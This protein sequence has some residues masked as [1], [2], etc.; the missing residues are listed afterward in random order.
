L[1]EAGIVIPV[2]INAKIFRDFAFFDSFLRQKRWRPLALFTGILLCSAFLCFI[3]RG[4][5]EQAV[6]LGGVLTAVGLGLPAAYFLSFLSS[7]K[8]QIKKMRLATQRHAY[9]LTLSGTEGIAV[10][11]G[12]EQL[13]YRWEEVFAVYRLRCCSYLYVAQNKAYLIPDANVEGGAEALWEMLK[14]T[15]PAGRLFDRR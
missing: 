1:H 2:S 9:T 8:T 11:T 4:R 12:N 10:K 3:M 5:A 14:T 15:V 13:T 7:V 6:L